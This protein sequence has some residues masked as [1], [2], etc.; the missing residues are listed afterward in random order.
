MISFLLG[1]LWFFC[2][3]WAGGCATCFDKADQRGDL[4]SSA[5]HVFGMM[6]ACFLQSCAAVQI[7][8]INYVL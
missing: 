2:M 5:W 1:L 3:L 8:R 4:G 7:Y 6:L